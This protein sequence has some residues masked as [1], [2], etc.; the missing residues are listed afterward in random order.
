MLDSIGLVLIGD[1][2]A[3]LRERSVLNMGA[4]GSKARLVLAFPGQT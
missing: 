3:T 4:F 1:F 2:V